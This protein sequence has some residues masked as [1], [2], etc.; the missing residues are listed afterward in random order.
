ME[1]EMA[2]PIETIVA[3]LDAELEPGR[4]RD[5]CPNGWQVQGRAQVSTLV[6]GVTASQALL[7]AAVALGA[8][9][10]LVHHGYFWQ[11]ENPVLVGMKYRRLRTL[12]CNDINLLAYHLPLD[13]HPRLGNNARLANLLGLESTGPLPGSEPPIGLVARLPTELTGAEFCDRVATALSRAPLHVAADRAVRTVALCTGAGQGLIDQAVAAGVDAF[14]T[15]EVSEPTVHSA[16]ENGIHF[17]AAGHHATE[18]YGV[19]ALGDWLAART[20][21]SHHFVDIP[22]PA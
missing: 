18:R 20:G 17:F 2:V 11:G 1:V 13:A 22:N 9:A 3:L 10:I 5:Y 19:Q 14:L 21:I 16:V 6:S 15:G 12:L 4:F 7:D 8:D